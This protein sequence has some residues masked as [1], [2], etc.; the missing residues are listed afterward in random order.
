MIMAASESECFFVYSADPSLT[1]LLTDVSPTHPLLVGKVWEGAELEIKGP[2]TAM[3]ETVG[4]ASL[5]GSAKISAK[6]CLPHGSYDIGFTT[7]PANFVKRN[8]FVPNLAEALG[9]ERI[10]PYMPEW[11][12][13]PESLH[14]NAVATLEAMFAG[15]LSGDQAA[16]Q[17]GLGWVSSN[18]GSLLAQTCACGNASTLPVPTTRFLF[19]DVIVEPPMPP[20]TPPTP[21]PPPT[22]DG[23]Q[24]TYI[25]GYTPLGTGSV[26]E[27]SEIDLDQKAMVTALGAKDYPLAQTH[28][29]VGGNSKTAAPFRTLKGFS[30]AAQ[31]EM[32][33]SCPGCPY[34]HFKQFYDYYGSFTYADDWAVAALGDAATGAG[35]VLTYTGAAA[36]SYDFGSASDAARGEAVRRGTAYLHVWM[37]AIR[38]FED[39][40]DD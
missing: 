20:P 35:K 39:A 22:Q 8:E 4:P 9:I 31:G 28:Y 34:K 7:P 37:Y 1:Y 30:T 11:K 10:K 32:Y 13:Y 23:A 17:A 29:S 33:D 12:L 15:L 38:E 3:P 2:V 14:A 36:W 16:V 18:E 26:V 5:P 40:I 25:A 19:P 24:A 6:F 21:T 27:A